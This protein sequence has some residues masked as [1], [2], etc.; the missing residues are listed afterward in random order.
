MENYD[1]IVIGGGPAGLQA[2]LSTRNSNPGVRIGLIRREEK[3]LIP[4]GIPY[5]LNSLQ[6]VDDNIMPDKPLQ[7]NDVDLIVGEVVSRTGDT[8]Q[9]ADGREFSF[10]RL[11]LATG[12]TAIVP[13]IEGIDLQGVFVVSK[14]YDSVKQL[15]EAAREANRVLIVGGGFIGLELADELLNAG[16]TVTLVE[17]CTHLLSRSFDLEFGDRVQGELE[18]RG[19]DV[20]VG[21]RLKQVLGDGQVTG[22]LLESGRQVPADMIIVSVGYKPNLTLARELGLEVEEGLGIVVDEYMRTS[23]PSVFAAGDCTLHKS[24]FTGQPDSV[25]LASS[26][27][28]QGRLAGSNLYDICVTKNFYGTL[29]TFATQIGDLAV[30]MTGLTERA[31][32]R[33]G[34][35]YLL[36]ITESVDRHPGKL[37]GASKLYIKLLFA[38]NA[39]VLL[40]AQVAGGTSVGEMVNMLSVMIQKR[41]TAMEIDT[42]QI[43]T[44][45]LLT[46]SP[47]AYP[48]I[49]ATVDA[50]LKW[51]TRPEYKKLGAQEGGNG[52]G[53]KGRKK[54]EV[55]PQLAVDQEKERW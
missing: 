5:T 6:S 10:V 27:M 32:L 30:G 16:K 15:R 21:H 8:L 50:I 26:A 40:G 52:D 36:G 34:Q 46:S 39:N 55:K 54:T 28:A 41:M 31:A 42:L 3:A 37:R 24:C 47:I 1:V 45:P 43:G 49:T 38:R 44:H 25:M 23:D 17:M 2:A 33:M 53:K 11:V 48:V 14:D 51:F 4:C 9:L 18:R 35:E 12:S 22:V 13:E 7:A 20:L 19:A 29:G